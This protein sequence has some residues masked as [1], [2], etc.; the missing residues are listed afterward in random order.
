[1]WLPAR[2][3]NVDDVAEQWVDDALVGAADEE[4]DAQYGALRMVHLHGHI[5]VGSAC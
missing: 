3:L 1:M 5:C 2:T 4:L